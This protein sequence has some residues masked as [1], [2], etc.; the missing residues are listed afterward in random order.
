MTLFLK[1]VVNIEHTT[2][3]FEQLSLNV[4]EPGTSPDW[5]M[6]TADHRYNLNDVVDMKQLLIELS[7]DVR[8]AIFIFVPYVATCSKRVLNQYL[9]APD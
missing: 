7:L 6:T 3:D 4:P 9:K 8:V 1:D 5:K 2:K